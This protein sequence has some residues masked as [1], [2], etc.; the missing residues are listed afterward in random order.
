LKID[1]PTAHD[2]NLV[3]PLLQRMSNLESLSLYFTIDYHEKSKFV[4]GN[5]LKRNILDHLLYLNELTFRI[6]SCILNQNYFPSNK[7]IENTFTNFNGIQVISYIDYFRNGA[8]GECH[9]YS[10][11]YTMK[12]FSRIT[13]HFPGGLFQSVRQITLFDNYSFAT[14]FFIRISQSFPLLEFLSLKNEHAQEEVKQ[15]ERSSNKNLIIIYPRLIKLNLVEAHNDYV[16]LFL[17]HTK[18]YLKNKIT[19]DIEYN[20]LQT[21][22]HGFTRETTRLNCTKVTRLE[23][24]SG[25]K[26]TEKFKAYFPHLNLQSISPYY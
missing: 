23:R 21:V 12:S 3:F 18:T 19:L 14:E 13:N 15:F 11:P 8:Y 17:D 9:M 25:F 1:T 2:E 5:D 22:T 16:Q 7:E 10:Y 24:C 6:D 4:D 26:M 20:D